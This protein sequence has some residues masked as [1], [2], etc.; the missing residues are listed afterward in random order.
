[1]D[2]ASGFYGI[3]ICPKDKAKTAF[4]TPDG[5]YQFTRMPFGLRN[6]PAVYSR[7][8]DIMLAGLKWRAQIVKSR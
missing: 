8:M 6:A 7:A 3:P 2:M 4:N 5:Q 1:M